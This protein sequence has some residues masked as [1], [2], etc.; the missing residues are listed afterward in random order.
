MNYRRQAINTIGDISG[1][2]I[3]AIHNTLNGYEYIGDT[4]KPFSVR[5]KQH[6]YKLENGIHHCRLLQA[7]WDTYGMNAFTFVVLECLDIP[8]RVFGRERHWFAQ[9]RG[10]LYNSIGPRQ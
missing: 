4:W 5:W 2:G 3:Y 9:S 7:D 1:F 6:L 10:H 8:D